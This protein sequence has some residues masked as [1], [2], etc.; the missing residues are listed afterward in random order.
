[1]SNDTIN[2]HYT[3]EKIAA[4]RKIRKLMEFW[5]ITPHEIRVAPRSMPQPLVPAKPPRYRHPISGETWD[6]EGRQPDWL[7]QALLREG[8]TVEEL[9]RAVEQ[10]AAAPADPADMSPGSAPLNTEDQVQPSQLESF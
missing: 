10:A 5:R 9:R 2:P 1:M 4:I 8:Y 7:R 3:P 6:G